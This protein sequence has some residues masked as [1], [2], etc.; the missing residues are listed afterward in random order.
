[1]VQRLVFM[2]GVM[3]RVVILVK[4][5]CGVPKSGMSVSVTVDTC[6]SA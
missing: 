3:A 1:M 6:S 2:L 4:G 5:A